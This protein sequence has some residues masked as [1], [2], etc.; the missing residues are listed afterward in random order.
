MSK[1]VAVEK[2]ANLKQAA[3]TNYT[4][5]YTKQNN[6]FGIFG[7]EEAFCCFKKISRSS[8][9]FINSQI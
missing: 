2:E 5:Q 3:A 7:G 6:N 9:I 4:I 1:A 8:G